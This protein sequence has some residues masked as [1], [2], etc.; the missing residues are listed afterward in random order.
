MLSMGSN[1]EAQTGALS[2]DYR[3]FYNVAPC[4]H[5]TIR[6]TTTLILLFC[7]V[8]HVLGP[9]LIGHVVGIF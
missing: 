6:M 5:V 2:P 3:G 7:N 8:I 4:L 9:T 1:L